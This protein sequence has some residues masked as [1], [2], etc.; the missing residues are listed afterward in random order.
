MKIKER[1]NFKKKKKK[2]MLEKE[3][4]NKETKWEKR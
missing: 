4:K 1:Q 2:K 3:R